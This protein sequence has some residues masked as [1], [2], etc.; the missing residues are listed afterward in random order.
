MLQQLRGLPLAAQ[1]WERDVLPARVDGFSPR[2]LEALFEEGEVV[3]VASA[4][5]DPRRA[6]VAFFARGEGRVCLPS[7]EESEELGTEAR[8]I[9]DFLKSEGT[10][11]RQRS[12]RSW[13]SRHSRS[14]AGSP[15]WPPA[16]WSPAIPAAPVIS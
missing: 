13:G 5:A 1:I 4:Q 7:I 6:R 15:S 2:D 3:W 9:Y 11:S 8:A 14:N 16:G 12:S 10:R